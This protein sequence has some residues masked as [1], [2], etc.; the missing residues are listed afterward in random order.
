MTDAGPNAASAPPSAWVDATLV[1]ALCAIDPACGG[2]SVRAGAGPVRDE[3]LEL[4]KSLLPD[5]APVRRIPAHVHDDRLLGGLD[6]VATLRAGRP[7]VE[8]G[9]LA[10]SNGGLVI[11]A[12]AERLGAMVAARLAAASES[13]EVV[14]ERDGITSRSPSRFV[15]A[16]LDEGSGDDERP[17]ALLLEHLAYHVELDHVALRETFDTRVDDSAVVAARARLAAVTIDDGCVEALCGAALALGVAS[18]RASLF[19][20]R[21][22]RGLAALAGC[23]SVEPTH[24]AAAARLVL[25]PRATRLPPAPA[26]EQRP[27]EP[28]APPDPPADDPAQPQP[29]AEDRPLEDVVLAAAAAAIPPGLLA[30][31]QIAAALQARGTGGGRAGQEQKGGARGR[32]AGVTRGEPRRGARLN[33]VETLRA[34]APWQ[35]VRRRLRAAQLGRTHGTRPRVEVR[36]DDFRVQRYRRHARTTTIFVVDASGSAALH[37]LG[38][39]KG[40]VE[41]LLGECYV[42]RDRVA[43]LAF[44][45]RAAELVLPP[46]RSLVRAK[47]SLAGLPGG[48]GTPLATGIEAGL[49]LA[50][51]TQRQGDTPVLVFLTDG[52]ANVTREGRPDRG[53]AEAQALAAA[54]CIRAAGF[55]A[56]LVDTAPRAQPLAEKVAEAMGA[57]YLPLPHAR[58]KDL[59][60]ALRSVARH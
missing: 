26:D 53:T 23:D 49:A 54:R 16:A 35:A 5:S 10:A 2:A 48:G 27:A 59:D 19:A 29:S 37:R 9:L 3:W 36:A 32:P 52:R 45:G 18:M 28:E 14:V 60:D 56:I 8:R 55:G 42:R 17:P 47:R 46:T 1:A 24:A 38:E 30:Q 58:S 4:L 40:A 51:A 34:A 6:L 21:A 25:A 13:G 20:V 12:G 22:A 50:T 57:R 31:L 33:V 11:V 39:A 15:V 7:V 44:R 43:L 41:L